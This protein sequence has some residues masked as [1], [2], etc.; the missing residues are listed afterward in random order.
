MTAGSTPGGKLPA[1]RLAGIGSLAT[2]VAVAL[3]V[4]GR[5][6]AQIVGARP[7]SALIRELSNHLPALVSG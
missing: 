3:Y 2:G 1:V 7:K 5:L 4:A 6:V